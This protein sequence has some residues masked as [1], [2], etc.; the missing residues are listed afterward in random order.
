MRRTHAARLLPPLSCLRGKIQQNQNPASRAARGHQALRGAHDWQK[1]LGAQTRAAHQNPIHLGQCQNLGGV[2]ARDRAAI[3]QRHS[4][5]RRAIL[6]CERAA[7]ICVARGNLLRLRRLAAANR[8]HRL[9]GKHG[10]GKPGGILRRRFQRAERLAAQHRARAPGLVIGLR[11]ADAHNRAHVLGAHGISARRHIRIAQ[12][13]RG[14]S[15]AVAAQNGL[16]ARLAQHGR[17]QLARMRARLRRV[18]GLRA[19]PYGGCVRQQSARTHQQSRRQAQHHLKPRRAAAER[20]LQSPQFRQIGFKPMHFP[21]ANQLE[22]AR[23]RILWHKTRGFGMRRRTK[24]KPPKKDERQNRQRGAKTQALRCAH[25]GFCPYGIALMLNRL[26]ESARGI[27]GFGLIGLLVIAFGAWGLADVAVDFTSD[28]VARLGSHTI[29]ASEFRALYANRLQSLSRNMPDVMSAEQGRNLGIDRQLLEDVIDARALSLGAEEMGLRIPDEAVV[30]LIVQDPTFFGPNGQFDEPTFRHVL[31]L[32]GITEKLYVRDQRQ[33]YLRQQFLRAF[34]P[35][36]FLPRAIVH[37]LYLYEQEERI[38]DYVRIGPAAIGDIGEPEPGALKEFYDNSRL[39][40]N[41]AERRSATI[42]QIQAAQF[43]K[44]VQLSE[45][46]VQQEFDRVADQYAVPEQREVDQLMLPDADSEAEIR[47]LRDKGRGFADFVQA[48]G[49]TAQSVDL[50]LVARNDFIVPELAEAAFALEVNQVSDI[51][52]T[53]LGAAILRV[54]RIVPAK[55]PRYAEI[56][57][58]L[59]TRLTQERAREE[60]Y[61]FQQNIED[62]L[63]AS[64]SFE[65]LAQQFDLALTTMTR[66]DRDGLNEAGRRPPMLDQSANLI[67]SIFNAAVGESIPPMETSAGDFLWLRV[68]E[69]QPARIAEFDAIADEVRAAWLESEQREL[70]D[71]LAQSLVA[72]GREGERFAALVEP[73]QLRPRRSEPLRRN[74]AHDVFAPGVLDA[75]FALEKEGLYGWGFTSGDNEVVVLQVH[76]ILRP[77]RAA[78]E[79]LDSAAGRAFAPFAERTRQQFRGDMTDELLR[80]LRAFYGVDINA[81][82]L[83]A[84]SGSVR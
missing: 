81:A 13:L 32:N 35:Q 24:R 44:A 58:E 6:C 53:P 46:E 12:R 84:A 2:L 83:H 63:A 72:R 62:E 29:R 73:L 78:L 37:E 40:W 70:L 34:D 61:A 7:Q 18:A 66:L 80:G 82:A 4:S 25:H 3:K 69:I 43:D 55:R 8:P 11:L 28:T 14:A 56:R 50:G 77:D 60:L 33:H 45:E 59:R 5:T 21:I 75:L 54:R 64:A 42:L 9:I 48:A 76:K 27:L 47:Q 15:L 22:I 68:D 23:G 19:Q 67:G 1:I 30:S 39:R 71:A 65:D 49:Q 41:Q 26:K 38:A 36:G 16:R 74:A 17:A 79:Q 52:E 31:S 51:I 20:F 10:P 57:D